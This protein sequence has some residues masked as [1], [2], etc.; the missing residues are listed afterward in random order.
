MLVPTYSQILL[1]HREQN[2]GDKA[3]QVD[4]GHQ[5]T[6]DSPEL[7]VVHCARRQLTANASIAA[8]QVGSYPCPPWHPRLIESAPDYDQQDGR[9]AGELPLPRTGVPGSKAVA[10][11]R[12]AGSAFVV[13]LTSSVREPLAI[14]GYGAL[15]ILIVTE[16]APPPPPTTVAAMS[17]S[18]VKTRLPGLAGPLLS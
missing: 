9:G 11:S 12:M 1:R 18:G 17:P 14:T 3:R 16:G 13:E 7:L 4:D 10:A 6:S 15:S 8:S 2:A 5:Q